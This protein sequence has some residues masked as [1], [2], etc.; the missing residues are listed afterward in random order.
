MK[1]TT[2]TLKRMIR[3]ELNNITK[4][5]ML[6]SPLDDLSELE[7]EAATIASQM[8]APDVK[9]EE[10][11]QNL[12]RMFAGELASGELSEEGMKLAIERAYSL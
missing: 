8:M 2:E 10:I 11:V 9:E 7:K 4:E 12:K 3:E 1:L 5:A 6:G